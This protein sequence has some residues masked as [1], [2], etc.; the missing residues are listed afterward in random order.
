[1]GLLISEVTLTVVHN[2]KRLS[3]TIDVQEDIL[4]FQWN[5]FVRFYAK[6]CAIEIVEQGK[7]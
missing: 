5:Y 4:E 7:P 2:G 1:M 6:Q 3:Y